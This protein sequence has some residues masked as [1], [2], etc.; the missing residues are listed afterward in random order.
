MADCVNAL[1]G[2]TGKACAS[3]LF[4]STVDE[5]TADGLFNKVKGRPNIS[6]IGFTTDGDVFGGFYS[7]AVTEQDEWFDDPTSFVF[8]FESHGRCKTPQRFVVKERLREKA[9]VWFWKDDR[10]GFVQFGVHDYSCFC[11][12]NEGSYSFCYAISF[13]FD[14]LEGTTLSGK[15]DFYY[16]DDGVYHFCSRLVAVQLS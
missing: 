9:F 14:G 2:W 3:I 1:K 8:S 7:V 13:A 12:G 10:N 6:T 4:D 11:L 15:K 5:F 16:S